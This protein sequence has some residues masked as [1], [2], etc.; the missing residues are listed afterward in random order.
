M[1]RATSQEAAVGRHLVPLHGTRGWESQGF[2]CI[3]SF[4]L[5]SFFCF[6]FH[7]TERMR[8]QKQSKEINQKQQQNKTKQKV[9]ENSTLNG[10]HIS[11][12]GVEWINGLSLTTGE[13]N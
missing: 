1:P 9:L 6:Q 8:H 13:G 10:N 12:T 5:S 7:C 2:V 4:L 3:V 11:E